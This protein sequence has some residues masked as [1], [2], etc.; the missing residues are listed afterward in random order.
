MGLLSHE[1]DATAGSA[2]AD[3]LEFEETFPESTAPVAPAAPVAAAH[4][5][6]QSR[7][8]AQPEPSF[9]EHLDRRL[10]EAEDR[11]RGAIEEMLF[12]WQTRFE[13][14]LDERRQEDER[15]A[16][17]R[18]VADEE[19]LRSWRAELE[20][21]LS[22]RFAERHASERALLPDRSGELRVTS[23][24]AVA[25]APSARDLGRIMRD[26]VNEVAH[27]TAFALAVHQDGRDEVAY[28]YRVASDDEL[29]Q[30]LRREALEDG[31][32]SAAAHADGW[33]RSQKTLRIGGRNVAVHTSQL[34]LRVDK[35]TVGVLT[36]QSEGD[37][38]ADS[39]LARIGDVARTAGPRLLALRG[40][41][42]LRG[43]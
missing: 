17:R 27:T 19:R 20:A 9:Q 40:S 8:Q 7:P 4:V 6:V 15:A 12:E 10:R 26:V 3:G 28:R 29:G 13:R 31:A 24:D 14:R 11:V 18:R 32:E 41:G 33:L 1:S 43:V 21:A 5:A 30:L 16:E 37:P 39:L 38:I 36:L 2:F 22:A 34:A 42:S 35:K 25:S 23:R